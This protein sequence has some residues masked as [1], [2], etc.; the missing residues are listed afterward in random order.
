[1]RKKATGLESRHTLFADKLAPIPHSHQAPSMMER[2]IVANPGLRCKR[3]TAAA[4]KVLALTL[5]LVRWVFIFRWA[6]CAVS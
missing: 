6:A 2:Q 1:M 4:F 5:Q 3:G